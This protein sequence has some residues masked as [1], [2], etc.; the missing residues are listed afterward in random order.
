[1]PAEDVSGWSETDYD[2]E[3][4][5]SALSDLDISNPATEGEETADTAE[6]VSIKGKGRAI[7]FCYY[8]VIVAAAADSCKTENDEWA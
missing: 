3:M 5:E 1:M 2:E 4:A 7:C 6:T 8:L